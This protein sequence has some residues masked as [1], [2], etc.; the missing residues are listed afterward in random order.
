MAY[1]KTNWQDTL[2]DGQGNLIQKGTPLNAQALGKIEDGI[3]GAEQKIDTEIGKVTQQLAQTTSYTTALSGDVFYNGLKLNRRKKAIMTIIDDDAKPSVWSLLKPVV[4]SEKVPITLGVITGR[5]GVSTESLTLAQLKELEK[6]G[7]EIQSHTV[8]HVDLST[9][10]TTEQKEYQIAESK[11]WLHENGFASDVLI[12]PFG[13]SDGETLT[14]TDRYYTAGVYIDGG[15]SV[16]NISPIQSN[17]LQRVYY[18]LTTPATEEDKN[19]VQHCKNKIDEAIA[20]NGW[21]IIGLHCFYDGFDPNGLREVI[22]YAKLKGVEIVNMKRG[23]QLYNNIIELPDFK[24]GADGE[25]SSSKLGHF[26]KMLSAATISTPLTE[27]PKDALS[28][29]SFNA[30]TATSSSMPENASGTLFNFRG[31]SDAYGK[32]IYILTN[33]GRMYGREW[34]SATS[35]WGAF[36]LINPRTVVKP[37][38]FNVGTLAALSSVEFNFSGSALTPAQWGVSVTPISAPPNGIIVFGYID[39]DGTVKVRITNITSA[40]IVC[41]SMSFNALLVSPT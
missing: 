37:G 18:N 41:G 29:R 34:N 35:A 27:F 14:L 21:I 5:V 25:I 3:V 4:E 9:L 36:A 32:Q 8:D 22:Q 33:N 10:S 6:I 7:F 30:S 31:A 2:R 26:V 24:V 40:S 38:T 17:K 23:L 13:G 16:I 12:Y 15:N 19:R 28:Y 11:R 39:S 20:N 1:Q